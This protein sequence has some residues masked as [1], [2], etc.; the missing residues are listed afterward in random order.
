[1][2]SCKIIQYKEENEFDVRYWEV[3][4]MVILILAKITIISRFLRSVTC[5]QIVDHLPSYSIFRRLLFTSKNYLS[6]YC[7]EKVNYN[8]KIA[9]LPILFYTIFLLIL[10]PNFSVTHSHSISEYFHYTLFSALFSAIGIVRI[11]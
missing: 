10:I 11:Y 1:M 9:D 4:I 8:I 3:L 6:F 5:N 2:V 7:Y